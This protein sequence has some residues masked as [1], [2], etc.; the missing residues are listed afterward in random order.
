MP[1]HSINIVEMRKIM[2]MIN[3]PGE[4][5]VSPGTGKTI[6]CP[7]HAN[8][9]SERLGLPLACYEYHDGSPNGA[10]I[11]DFQRWLERRSIIDSL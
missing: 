1:V 5:C 7:H 2:Q 9:V 11:G 4:T 8:T 3:Q 10:M 6:E